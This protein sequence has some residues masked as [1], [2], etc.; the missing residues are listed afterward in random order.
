MGALLRE[1]QREAL[2][3]FLKAPAQGYGTENGPGV[4]PGTSRGGVS[5]GSNIGTGW[6]QGRKNDTEQTQVEKVTPDHQVWW[7]QGWWV[8]AGEQAGGPS[9][10][11]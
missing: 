6:I 8:Q 2:A 10:G 4:P 7:D 5:S 1:M 3:L 9:G 11:G